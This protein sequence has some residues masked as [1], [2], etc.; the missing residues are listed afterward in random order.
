MKII[1]NTFIFFTFL[2]ALKSESIDIST[3]LS[4]DDYIRSFP[5]KVFLDD[6]NTI[7]EEFFSKLES[8]SE[9]KTLKGKLQ[10][11][12]NERGLKNISISIEPYHTSEGGDPISIMNY[13]N[14]L[15]TSLRDIQKIPITKA[16]LKFKRISF[17]SGI[18]YENNNDSI[19]IPFPPTEGIWYRFLTVEGKNHPEFQKYLKKRREDTLNSINNLI[20]D[21]SDDMARINYILNNL[22]SNDNSSFKNHAELRM[23]PLFK[24]D[25]IAIKKDYSLDI[26]G[27][28]YT[29]FYNHFIN[30]TNELS[31]FKKGVIKHSLQTKY[32][33]TKIKIDSDC[34]IV[35]GKVNN[36]KSGINSSTFNIDESGR[37][38]RE[39]YYNPDVTILT[40]NDDCLGTNNN[41][42]Q[43]LELGLDVDK[44]I[45]ALLDT[46]VDYNDPKI[47][48]HLAR[49]PKYAR[50]MEEKALNSLKVLQEKLLELNNKGWLEKAAMSLSNYNYTTRL[51]D[52]QK[53]IV[54]NNIILERVQEI[55]KNGKTFVGRD[56][57]DEDDTP[58]DYYEGSI[59]NP[60]QRQHGTSMAKIL[61]QSG[62]DISILNVKYPQSGHDQEKRMADAI[63]YSANFGANIINM[64]FGE[65]KSVGEAIKAS[66]EKH[67]NILFVSAAGNVMGHDYSI[68]KRNLENNPTYPAVYQLENHL[69]VAN[70]NNDSKSLSKISCFSNKIVEIGIHSKDATSGSATEVSRIAGRIKKICSKFNAIDLKKHLLKTATEVEELKPFIKNGA[71]VNE[72]RAIEEAKKICAN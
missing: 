69:T 14:A 72:E 39:F 11:E 5:S 24:Q 56:F 10:A 3:N 20:P 18:R 38:Y 31:L 26:E 66:M 25:K 67:K 12:L 51:K 6:N 63:D 37:V 47:S 8:D 19:V 2:F 45:I 44:I 42:D 57:H 60:T 41:L 54:Q 64:S 68:K 16:T 7:E 70:L 13:R 58:F 36:Y 50:E 59:F 48:V 46:G 21:A 62:D 9:I 49:V 52:I 30:G 17:V 4:Y 15:K 1:R 34:L 40:S 53:L 29:I 23:H 27:D 43:V 33:V 28:T 65:H 71:V 35:D 55:R 22:C 61:S 32:L